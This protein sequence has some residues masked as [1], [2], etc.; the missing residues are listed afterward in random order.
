MRNR[1]NGAY[2]ENF[3]LFKIASVIF[4]VTRSVSPV[5]VVNCSKTKKKKD[6]HS[7]NCILTTPTGEPLRET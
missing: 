3:M 5:G 1:F 2:M 6:N 4:S 7:E